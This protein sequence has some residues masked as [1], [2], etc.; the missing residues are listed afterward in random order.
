[1][2]S[3]AGF[4]KGLG[5]ASLS[6]GPKAVLSVK[7]SRIGIGKTLVVV[8]PGHRASNLCEQVF[9]RGR[10]LPIFQTNDVDFFTLQGEFV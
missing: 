2:E 1:M 8:L 9:F 10:S 7:C 3:D 5:M 4:L 6:A